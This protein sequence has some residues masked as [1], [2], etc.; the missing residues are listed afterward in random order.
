M[1]SQF[2]TVPVNI[3]GPSYKDRSRTLSSQETRNFYQELVDSGKDKYVIKSF[4][5]QLN[6]TTQTAGTDR[7][8]HQMSEIAY[9]VVGTTLFKV[10]S[11]GSRTDLGT[12]PGYDR[13]IF[14]DDGVNLFIVASNNVYHYDD[15]A[16]TLAIVT[17]TSIVGAQSVAFINNQFA[18]T[19]PLL[20]VFSVVGDGSSASSL[21]AVGAESDPDELVRDYTFD[22][23]LYRF[24]TRTCENW[25]NSGVGVPPFDRIEGQIINIGLGAIHSVNNSKDFV[26]WLGSDLQVYRARGGQEQA[27]STA[28]I[29]GAIQSYSYIGDAFGEVATIDNKVIYI[30]TFPTANKT[31]C[32]IEE[33]GVNG[34]FELS[35]GVT[36]G[37]WNAGSVLE[38]YNKV[39]IGD[40]SN[41]NLNEL[42]F[43]TYSQAG[44]TWRRRRILASVN[45]D[46]FGQKGQR[47]EMS[48]MEFII[49]TGTGLVT[50]QGDD[51]QI[52]IEASYDGG[53]SW[54]EGKW[55]KIGRQGEFNIRAEWY[56]MKSFYDM[57]VR[58]TT[59]DPVAF[60]IYSAAIDLRL[61]GR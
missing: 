39:L 20:T 28:A 7:G 22:Q 31:W 37:R 16:G 61:A 26:Y 50:G 24:G 6:I 30:L 4:P 2:Q 15:G 41:G 19:F 10:L 57:M 18:Y 49:E 5:G 33:L 27:I 35:E 17:D 45:G 34:W 47:V 1:E 51:P 55:L 54:D 23:I 59:S 29:S 36:K 21:N 52:M 46:I 58:L 53:R 8:M 13:C 25:Y 56:S 32:L 12:I 60:N 48:R 14:A 11:D 42:D 3:T 43:D 44:E 38:V 40:R 9:R